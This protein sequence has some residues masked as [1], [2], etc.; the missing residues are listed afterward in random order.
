MWPVKL[1]W[2]QFRF[3]YSLLLILKKET[4]ADAFW[5]FCTK[6]LL[7]QSQGLIEA[8]GKIWGYSKNDRPSICFWSLNMSIKLTVTKIWKFGDNP[9]ESVNLVICRVNQK[10]RKVN[11]KVSQRI[12]WLLKTFKYHPLEIIINFLN[13]PDIYF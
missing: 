2:D 1:V 12:L 6:I 5:L 13:N 7:S 3:D 9:K 11:L 8:R 10:R 4:C